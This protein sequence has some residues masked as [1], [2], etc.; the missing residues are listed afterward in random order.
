MV[1]KDIKVICID[2][3]VFSKS[4]TYGKTYIVMEEDKEYGR[5]YLED[6]ESRERWFCWSKFK[7]I[8]EFRNDIINKILE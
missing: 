6:D 4:I 5:Y 8:V 3:N 2:D 1:V 7:E